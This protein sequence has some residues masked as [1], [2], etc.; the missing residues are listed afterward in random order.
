MT[1]P[2]QAKGGSAAPSK[3]QRAGQWQTAARVMQARSSIVRGVTST[4]AAMRYNI[5]EAA[6]RRPVRKERCYS[7]STYSYRRWNVSED[8]PG[9]SRT[10]YRRLLGPLVRPVKND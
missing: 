10:R 3:Q 8:R 5:N 9:E 1:P 7:D 2:G 4:A 6:G